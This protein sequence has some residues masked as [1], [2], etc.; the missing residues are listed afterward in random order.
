MCT[1]YDS[2]AQY[3]YVYVK[4]TP[5]WFLLFF[6][7]LF[8]SK[9]SC[10]LKHHAHKP[11]YF[12]I[13]SII[14]VVSGVASTTKLLTIKYG[15][16]MCLDKNTT[17]QLLMS[18]HTAYIVLISPHWEQK[19]WPWWQLSMPWFYCTIPPLLTD[20]ATDTMSAACI[21]LAPH[22]DG[23]DFRFWLSQCDVDFRTPASFDSLKFA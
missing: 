23:D 20:D 16:T 11:W 4:I 8:L 3:Y 22:D 17:V 10:H 6:V 2:I 21:I 14:L 15:I 1:W 13:G 9:L 12:L 19:E 18:L 7:S 5:R